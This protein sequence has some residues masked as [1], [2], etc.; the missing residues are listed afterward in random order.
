M[1]KSDIILLLSNVRMISSATNPHVCGDHARMWSM[2]AFHSCATF[3]KRINIDDFA[4]LLAN[5]SLFSIF[6][7]AAVPPCASHPQTC[8]KTKP[9]Y[10]MV[11][12]HDYLQVWRHYLLHPFEV[13]K[14]SPPEA[15]YQHFDWIFDPM[16]N[17]PLQKDGWSNTFQAR[18]KQSKTDIRPL[19][20][21]ELC[22]RRPHHWCCPKPRCQ[23]LRCFF[24]R[25]ARATER[26]EQRN[27]TAKTWCGAGAA[28]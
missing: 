14:N 20:K 19:W 8:N 11:I 23:G 9:Q 13:T 16:G 7:A 12:I 24:S 2:R 4:H 26:R 18:G 27:A 10:F 5:V 25:A 1:L 22:G 28:R 21:W 17:P 15:G 6:H 3:N